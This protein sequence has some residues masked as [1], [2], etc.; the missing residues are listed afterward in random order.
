MVINLPFPIQHLS[1][2]TYTV[3][4]TDSVMIDY[5]VKCY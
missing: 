4:E 5:F 3:D 1:G 2:Y